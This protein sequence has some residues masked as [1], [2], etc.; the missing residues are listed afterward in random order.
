MPHPSDDLAAFVADLR[1]RL[2]RGELAGH[3][4]IDLGN[5]HTPPNVERAVRRMLADVAMFRAIDPA[6]APA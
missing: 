2:E 5:A 1:R 3:P 4:P 6:G